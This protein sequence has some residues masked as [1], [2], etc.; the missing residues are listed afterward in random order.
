[1]QGISRYVNRNIVFETQAAIIVQQRQDKEGWRNLEWRNDL[2]YFWLFIMYS[3]MKH[4][5]WTIIRSLIK[6]NSWKSS[7]YVM[8]LMWNDCFVYDISA[9]HSGIGPSD[10]ACLMTIWEILLCFFGI[11]LVMYSSLL[12]GNS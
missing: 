2:C 8:H 1:M 3:T 12:G 9:R 5:F 4:F 10:I 7:L 6:F 11:F